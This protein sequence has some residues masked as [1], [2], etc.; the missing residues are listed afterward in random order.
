M[1]DFPDWNAPQGHAT[2]ISTTGAPLL[3][4]YSLLANINTNISAG[5]T[6][7]LPV[8]GI[9][10]I[11]QPGYE[12]LFQIAAPSSLQ[13]IVTVEMTWFDSTSGIISAYRRFRFFAGASGTPHIVE[14]HG[15]SNANQ[16]TVKITAG[17]QAIAIAGAILQSSRIYLNHVWRTAN[18]AQTPPV[19]PGFTYA[20]GDFAAGILLAAEDSLLLSTNKKYLLPLYTGDVTWNGRDSSGLSGKSQYQILAEPETGFT[21]TVIAIRGA[22]Q[23]GFAGFNPSSMEGG[24]TLPGVQCSH[25]Y[26]NLDTTTTRT[27]D[28]NIIIS[29]K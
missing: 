6:L 2:A 27:L 22:G 13:S 9:F 21:N 28:A 8:T 10:N 4:L 25:Q 23:S 19:F 15:P 24:V 3:N 16:L 29:Q 11:T 26:F 14:G 5:A 20:P 7:T 17:A 12:A 1:T 18:T